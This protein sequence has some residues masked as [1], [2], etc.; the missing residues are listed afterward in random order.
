MVMTLIMAGEPI[1]LIIT[2]TDMVILP[3]TEWASAT[4]PIMGWD[5]AT[6]RILVMD[7]ATILITVTAGI[8]PITIGEEI[9]TGATPEIHGEIIIPITLQGFT[10]QDQERI[11]PAAVWSQEKIFPIR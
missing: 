6:L 4:P 7:M 8:T 11:T 3:I 10:I 5:S 2:V 1:L 9:I